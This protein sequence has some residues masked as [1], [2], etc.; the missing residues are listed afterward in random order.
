MP[1]ISEPSEPIPDKNIKYECI[2][3]WIE[4]RMLPVLLKSG[5]VNQDAYNTILE[6]YIK[7][8]ESIEANTKHA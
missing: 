6:D 7:T 3:L 2:K 1:K 8:V 4:K 5:V